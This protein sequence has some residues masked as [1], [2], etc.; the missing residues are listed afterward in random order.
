MTDVAATPVSSDAI[1]SQCQVHWGAFMSNLSSEPDVNIRLERWL[2]VIR[3]AHEQVKSLSDELTGTAVKLTGACSLL[4]AGAQKS[5]AAAT[6]AA[7]RCEA[8]SAQ[9]DKLRQGVQQAVD[10]AQT[11]IHSTR[12]L[13][14]DS[15]A[16]KKALIDTLH[17]EI[18]QARGD[19]ASLKLQC[20]QMLD[21]TRQSAQVLASRIEAEARDVM[22]QAQAALDE[23]RVQQQAAAAHAASAAV[24]SA[25]LTSA[26][27]ILATPVVSAAVPDTAVTPAQTSVNASASETP[28]SSTT[29]PPLA[30]ASDTHA[31]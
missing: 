23:A 20:D 30:T 17:A 4:Q 9:V 11:S 24:A 2:D 15:T 25:T 29:P 13:L 14:D 12:A 7:A 10:D 16:Q 5:E 26:A 28:L 3:D 1:R 6:A 31:A 8:Y 27:T 21:H 22:A 18:E 19:L